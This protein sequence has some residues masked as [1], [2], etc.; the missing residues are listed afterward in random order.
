VLGLAVAAHLHSPS[1]SARYLLALLILLLPTL[2]IAL[3]AFLVDILIFVPHLQWG[4]WIVLAST[5]LIT[6]SGVVTCAMRRTL[7]SRKA[8]KKRIAENA[9]MS[10]ANFY[11]RQ[12]EESKMVPSTSTESRTQMMNDSPAAE[13]LPTFTTYTSRRSQER[14]MHA[15]SPAEPVPAT[16]PIDSGRYYG[17]GGQRSR[18]NSR[19]RQEDFGAPLGASRSYDDRPTVPAMPPTPNRGAYGPVRGGYSTR[20]S[21]SGRSVPPSP[22]RGRGGYPSRGRGGYPSGPNGPGMPGLMV[23]AGVNRRPP[24]GYGPQSPTGMDG[25]Y[26]PPSGPDGNYSRPGDPGF[27]PPSPSNYGSDAPAGYGGSAYGSRAQSPA[28]RRQSPYGSRIQSPSRGLPPQ[29]NA[30][31]MPPVPDQYNPEA[32]VAYGGVPYASRSQSPSRGLPPQD[33]P[34]AMPPVP[35]QYGPEVPV[36]YSGVPYG[37]R[38]QSPAARRQSPYGSRAQSPARGMPF[39][40]MPPAMPPVPDHYGPAVQQPT[41]MGM[42]PGSRDMA[43]M[44]TSQPQVMHQVSGGQE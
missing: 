35:D 18:S 4:G 36:A 8:R 32:S 22:Y 41:A 11:A 2:L 26:G 27:E 14:P 10:G 42:D 28:T 40:D 15:P 6:A 44:E 30:P 33:I 39:Q 16:S 24:P 1:H 17:H 12:A 3:L 37:S 13:H 19:P 20:G 25:G 9:E 7:V 34:P 5:I 23:P 31:A 21:F 38:A 43:E 29:D